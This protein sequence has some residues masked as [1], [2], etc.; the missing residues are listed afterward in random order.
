MLLHVNVSWRVGKLYIRLLLETAKYHN[1]L[2]IIN[3]LR[4]A[5]LMLKLKQAKQR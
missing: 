4:L 1:T 5:Q 3:N 2:F